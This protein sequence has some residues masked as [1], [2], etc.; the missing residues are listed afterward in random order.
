VIGTYTTGIGRA[1]KYAEYHRKFFGCPMVAT[2]N[3]EVDGSLLDFEPCLQAR[4]GTQYW[5]IKVAGLYYAWAIRIKDTRQPRHLIELVSKAPLPEHLKE[6]QQRIEVMEPWDGDYITRWHKEAI[7]GDRKWYQTFTWCEDNSADS[8]LIWNTI[9]P[10]GEWSGAEVLDYGCFTGYHS[11]RA[12]K[13]GARVWAWDK[14]ERCR[15]W[16]RQINDHVEMQDV[17]VCDCAPADHMFDYIF[18][19]SVHHQHDPHYKELGRTLFDLGSQARKAV[20]LELIEPPMYGDWDRINEAVGGRKPL[21]SYKHKIRGQRS[22][23][24]LRH[25]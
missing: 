10:L 4:D 13:C 17:M 9:Y 5:L 12:S 22:I 3:M 18:Y 1:H 25:D 21:L 6:G 8:E 2:F 16:T 11:F 24:E 7:A 19:F 20:F 14:D 15:T 23:W